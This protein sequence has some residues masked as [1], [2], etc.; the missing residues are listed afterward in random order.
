MYFRA[1]RF[2]AL[3]RREHLKAYLGR[4]SSEVG[5]PA[6]PVRT[7]DEWFQLEVFRP[8][9]KRDQGVKADAKGSQVRYSVEP[10]PELERWTSCFTEQDIELFVGTEMKDVLNSSYEPTRAACAVCEGA[11]RALVLPPS[12]SAGRRDTIAL[13][14]E[15]WLKAIRDL[16]TLPGPRVTQVRGHIDRGRR[17]IA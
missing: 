5:A 11:L 13:Q 9:L 10:Q 6:V 15:G 16:A 2:L 14:K 17:S 4:L 8:Y 7:F 3:V 1:E 12:L